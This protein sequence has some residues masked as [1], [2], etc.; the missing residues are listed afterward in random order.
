MSLVNIGAGVAAYLCFPGSLIS[1]RDGDGAFK[2][3]LPRE[4]VKSDL[5]KLS[6]RV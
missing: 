2:Q 6:W 1:G 4:K 5:R 3:S